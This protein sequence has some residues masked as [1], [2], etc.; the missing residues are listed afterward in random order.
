MKLYEIT[1]VFAD[2]MCNVV[3]YIFDHYKPNEEFR[4]SDNKCF[5]EIY[6]GDILNIPIYLASTN[7]LRCYI[8]NNNTIGILVYDS[9]RE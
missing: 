5:D 6:T 3:V 4:L 8:E 9:K 7:V 2:S 1:D